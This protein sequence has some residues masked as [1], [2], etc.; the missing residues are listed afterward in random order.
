MKK[1]I[2]LMAACALMATVLFAV[3]VQATPYAEYPYIYEDLENGTPGNFGLLSNGT[4]ATHGVKAD[5]TGRSGYV[6]GVSIAP[7]NAN[8]SYVEAVKIQDIPVVMGTTMKSSLMV[9]MATGTPRTNNVSIV[10]SLTGT[11]LT[12][13]GEK[14]EQTFNGWFEQPL[15]ITWTPGAWQKLESRITW[16]KNL[17]YGV[18]GSTPLNGNTIDYDSV[19]IYRIQFRI[20]AGNNAGFIVDESKLSDGASTLD[21]YFD[22]MTY[23]PYA[24]TSAPVIPANYNKLKFSTFDN[25]YADGNGFNAGYMISNDAGANKAALSAKSESP[26]YEGAGSYINLSS[27]DGAYAFNEFMINQQAHANILWSANHMY[28]VSFWF[29]ANEMFTKTNTTATSGH[30]GIKLQMTSGSLNTTDVNGLTG[31]ESWA[32]IP[33]TNVLPID[34]QWH[35]VTVNFQLELKTFAEL[36]RNGAPMQIGLIPYVNAANRWDA[37]HLNVDLDD[38]VI[39][40]LGPL[41]NGS[42]ETGAGKSVR[43]RSS[44]GKPSINTVDH[45]LFGWNTGGN[46]IE[47]SSDVRANA[48]SGST[49]SAKVTITAAES[50]INQGLA[51]EKDIPRYKM[52]FWAKTDVAD[53][54]SKPIALDLDRS[55]TTTEQAQEYYDTPN[56][57][58]YIG[59]DTVI[60]SD[61][62]SYAADASQE[63]KLTNEWQ[64]YECV[65]DNIFDAIPGHE[66]VN[67]SKIKP[68]QPFMYFDVNG[69]AAGTQYYVDDVLL[70]VYEEPV[71]FDYPY[72]EN[73]AVV[74]GE[75]VAGETVTISYDFMSDKG[76]TE[77]ETVGRVMIA[78]EPSS[79]AWAC[80]KQI[81][82]EN[83]EV[84]FVL[85]DYILGKFVKVEFMPVDENNLSGVVSAISLG[86]VKDA[87]T[88]T[89]VITGWSE[90]ES[91][92]NANVSVEINLSTIE[93]Q[94]MTFILAVYNEKNK[95]VSSSAVTKTVSYGDKVTIPVSASFAGTDASHAKLYV[96]S[97]TSMN[98]AGK[99]AYCDEI[100]S[101]R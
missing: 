4:G 20:G 90:M 17:A 22:E 11:T 49:K 33:H 74:S 36:Y 94:E 7:K 40:D 29:R 55:A 8:N 56:Y 86:E 54:E 25:P 10:Y 79:K 89:P 28:E 61:T 5:P 30:L 21:F 3:P 72:V 15:S 45:N 71:L 99:M 88:V 60:K 101:V 57:E 78:N 70:E 14:S 52:S 48:D 84:T 34:K 18:S 64:Y 97:G 63:W 100:S 9:Y 24:N 19:K 23:E 96:W 82:A 51:L 59:K 98:D 6:Y 87:F 16:S 1:I 85:P 95:M 81:P 83:G 75:M 67:T 42:F 13:E 66:T 53:G 46:T 65:I 35:K 77:K 38:L 50:N 47:H 73:V 68:R 43:V 12:A 44:E 80:I 92:V 31:L 62:Y 32:S 41:T 37:V 91:A 69:N 26:A 2:S 39:R 27:P 76:M 93:P 58:F